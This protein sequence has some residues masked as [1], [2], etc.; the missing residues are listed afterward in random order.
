MS[1]PQFDRQLADLQETC[2]RLQQELSDLRER[3]AELGSKRLG[4]SVS[5]HPSTVVPLE[6]QSE[7]PLARA[8]W[9]E[10]VDPIPAEVPDSPA[11]Q[12]HPERPSGMLGDA[13]A[14]L[15]ASRRESERE[16]TGQATTDHSIHEGEPDRTLELRIGGTWLNRAGAVILFLAIAFFAKYSFDR[17]GSVKPHG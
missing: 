11:P 4:D 3:I 6:Q 13:L 7:P 15:I 10:P 1:D 2:N 14:R 16:E 9:I 12:A 8:D 5:R 17:A